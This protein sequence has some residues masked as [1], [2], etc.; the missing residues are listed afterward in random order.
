MSLSS[1]ISDL[2][3]RI[4]LEFKS[5][6]TELALNKTNN[7]IVGTGRP[8]I[9]SSLS[10]INQSKTSSAL[11]GAT[12]ISTDGAGVGAWTW[13]KKDNTWQITYGDTGTRAIT[14][15]RSFVTSGYVYIQRTTH[16]VVTSFGGGAYDSISLNTITRRSVVL[17]SEGIPVGFRTKSA[18]IGFVTDDGVG[19]IA[20]V[21]M[22]PTSDG[23]AIQFRG[24]KSTATSYARPS[25]LITTPFESWPTTL[26]GTPI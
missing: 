2:A 12:F 1:A 5:V 20:S 7:I 10:S 23:N 16:N 17:A 4:G 3:N 6:R 19:F 22:T 25:T 14:P 11:T 21:Y 26:P 13:I 15:N 18:G 9:S 24:D 8:D